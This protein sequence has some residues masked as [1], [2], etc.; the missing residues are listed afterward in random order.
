[1]KKNIPQKHN[2]SNQRIDPIAEQFSGKNLT[3]FGGSGLI[4]RFFENHR[5]KER[6]ENS[7]KVQGRRK[8]KY[9]V[10][11]MLIGCLYGM[12][13]G[14]PRPGQMEVLST[15]RVFQSIAGLVS[16]PVQSTISRFLKRVKVSVAKE[17]AI[18]TLIC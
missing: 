8:S 9:G 17:M 18:S 2:K 5:I 7:V 12:F 13:L 14:Y 15:D 6:I 3:R 1:M 4:R 10:V 11:D 16:F